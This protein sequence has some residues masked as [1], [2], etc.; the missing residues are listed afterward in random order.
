MRRGAAA[1]CRAAPI[2]PEDGSMEKSLIDL[3]CSRAPTNPAPSQ[4]GQEALQQ[5]M[6]RYLETEVRAELRAAGVGPRVPP[7]QWDFEGLLAGMRRLTAGRHD[8][9]RLQAGLAPLGPPQFLPGVAAEDIRLACAAGGALPR[10]RPLPPAHAPS[11]AVAAAMAGV[12]VT[13][14]GS[15]GATSSTRSRD[16]ADWQP[17]M[18][19]E[20]VRAQA[21]AMAIVGRVESKRRA[22]GLFARPGAWALQADILEAYLIA[23]SIELYRDRIERLLAGGATPEE[24]E[25]AERRWVLKAIDE[26]WSQ[27][28]AT[29]AVLRNS[30][31]LR[32][33]GL[34][35]PL[36]EYNIDGARAFEALVQGMRRRACENLFFFTDTT[37]SEAADADKEL[38]QAQLDLERRRKGGLAAASSA[39]RSSG[40]G[41]DGSASVS[42]SEELLQGNSPPEVVRKMGRS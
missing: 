3:G 35:E 22:R 8:H 17:D 21:A 42:D 1:V 13:V 23:T 40:G 12:P 39:V 28:L 41:D 2:Q 32:S 15:L 30:C 29:M 20:A 38:Q 16:P 24:V 26:A 19:I 7:A 36:E 27:H 9:L 25:E 33:F 18:E 34:V 37:S 5:R 10:G 6:F 11:L 4:D 14:Q 31:N